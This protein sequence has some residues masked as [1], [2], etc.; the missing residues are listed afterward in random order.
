MFA[1]ILGCD[2]CSCEGLSEADQ[3]VLK[4]VQWFWETMGAYNP[5]AGVT[6][7][8]ASSMRS[9]YE[10][11]RAERPTGPSEVP[12]PSSRARR[13][14]P[15]IALAS[16]TWRRPSISAGSRSARCWPAPGGGVDLPASDRRGVYRHLVGHHEEFGKEAPPF[17]EISS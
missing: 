3:A 9:Y 17:E 1:S 12:I 5:D 8:T 15:P 13:R 14:A 11:E 4:H 2:C 6:R 16:L 10:D 7:T